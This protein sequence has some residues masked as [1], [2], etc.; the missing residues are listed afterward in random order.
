M[1]EPFEKPVSGVARV[2]WELL[3]PFFDSFADEISAQARKSPKAPASGATLRRTRAQIAL[4]RAALAGTAAAALLPA[5]RPAGMSMGELALAIAGARGA[6]AALGA[7][8]FDTAAHRAVR[9][10]GRHAGRH[11]DEMRRE[12]SKRFVRLF[13]EERQSMIKAGKWPAEIPP[14]APIEFSH[15]MLQPPPA[16][17][18]KK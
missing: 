6:L 9:G 18:P 2:R 16:A 11:I 1:Q 10:E 12:L 8:P 3:T 17:P 7:L 13:K 4:V 14:D 15:P 5:F